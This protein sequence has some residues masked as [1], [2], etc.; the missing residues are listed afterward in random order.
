MKKITCMEEHVDAV[1]PYQYVIKM[2]K[3]DNDIISKAR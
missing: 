2:M 1:P 3:S